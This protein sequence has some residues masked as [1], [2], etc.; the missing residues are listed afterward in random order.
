[1]IFNWRKHLSYLVLIVGMI[2]CEIPNEENMALKEQNF[3]FSTEK[4]FESEITRLVNKSG[5]IKTVVFNAV[6]DSIEMD[7][8]DFE[9]EFVPFI[10]SDINKIIWLD[11]YECDTLYQHEGSRNL[12][13]I[14]S[15]ICR[16]LDDKL[17]TK[18]LVVHF[19]LGKVSSISIEN[20]MRKMLMDT[21]ES[22][23][24]ITDR[25]YEVIRVQKLKTG[26]LDSTYMKVIFK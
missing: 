11:K 19:A 26:G 5:F 25:E 24:Y 10:N 23:T 9:R 22:M 16:S 3:F 20:R 14:N 7:S 18:S 8:L 12:D 1:M 13:N 2:A 15:I 17:K 21:K 4:F 6:S